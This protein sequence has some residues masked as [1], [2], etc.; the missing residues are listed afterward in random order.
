MTIASPRG[1]RRYTRDVGMLS[2]PPL[3]PPVQKPARSG[4]LT[5]SGSRPIDP[6]SIK[7]KIADFWTK[8]P[9]PQEDRA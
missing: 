9:I 1:V 8:A 6:E 4:T 5:G 3:P 2:G 7:R